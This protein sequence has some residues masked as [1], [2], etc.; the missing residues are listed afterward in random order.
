M[1]CGM[2]LHMH[3]LFFGMHNDLVS[4]SKIHIFMLYVTGSVKN[5]HLVSATKIE[6]A[7]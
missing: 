1:L 7:Q 4:C 6:I 2:Y 3:T 5:D